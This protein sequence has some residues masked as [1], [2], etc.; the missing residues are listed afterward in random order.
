MEVCQSGNPEYMPRKRRYKEN[1]TIL[2]SHKCPLCGKTGHLPQ[3]CHLA[4]GKFINVDN[5][6]RG[7]N[8]D[9]SQH[10]LKGDQLSQAERMEV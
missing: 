4:S 10:Y 8:P 3:D 5:F 2:D 9:T 1:V 6:E 7:E